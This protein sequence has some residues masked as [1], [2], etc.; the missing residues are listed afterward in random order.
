M[1][2]FAAVFL[3]TGLTLLAQGQK[4]G[5]KKA[6]AENKCFDTAMKDIKLPKYEG[7]PNYANASRRTPWSAS[8][9]PIDMNWR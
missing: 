4:K 3:I 6:A 1:K 2:H 5:L 8:K 7:W 9:S